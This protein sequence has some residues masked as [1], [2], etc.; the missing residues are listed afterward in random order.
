MQPLLPMFAGDVGAL[1]LPTWLL[2][3]GYGD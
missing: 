1:G 2:S 3:G